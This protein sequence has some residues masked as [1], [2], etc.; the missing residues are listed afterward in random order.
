ML[1]GNRE[2]YRRKMMKNLHDVARIIGPDDMV[3][4]NLKGSKGYRI[5]LYVRNYIT[6]SSTTRITTTTMVIRGVKKCGLHCAIKPLSFIYSV[7]LCIIANFL[8]LF[9]FI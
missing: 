9:L 8:N 5:F 7:L 1:S 4:L 2:M 6:V 3:E